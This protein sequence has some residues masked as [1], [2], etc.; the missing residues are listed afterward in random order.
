MARLTLR[1]KR[2]AQAKRRRA[3]IAGGVA[4][5]TAATAAVV[6]RKYRP[7][8]DGASPEGGATA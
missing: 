1:P 3:A 8:K 5:G 4:T 6:W 7:G 2:K